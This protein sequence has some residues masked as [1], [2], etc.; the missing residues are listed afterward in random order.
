MRS[1]TKRDNI[2][3]LHFFN[4]LLNIGQHEWG[5][6]NFSWILKFFL[7]VGHVLGHTILVSMF[8]KRL[9]IENLPYLFIA[10]ALLTIIGTSVFSIFIQKV[11]KQSLIAYL[12]FGAMVLLFIAYAVLPINVYLFYVVALIASSILLSQLTIVLALFI[13]EQFSPSESERTFPI[14]ESSELVGALTAG[15]LITTLNFHT[16]E[17]IILWM[18][19]TACLLVTLM[20]Y[21]RQSHRYPSLKIRQAKESIHAV[22]H[23]REGLQ[24]LKSLP[25]L[26][27]MMGIAFI[28]FA[29]A[30]IIEFQ[31]TKALHA[32]AG[33]GEDALTHELGLYV[34]IFS[35]VGLILQLFFASRIVHKLGVIKALILHP[36]IV[37]IG[38]SGMTVNYNTA[39]AVGA[40]F[41]YDISNV[42][43]R[44]AYLSS[45]YVVHHKIRERAKALIEGWI[46]PLGM[47][48]G[49]GSILLL[50]QVLH[51]KVLTFALNVLLVC[52]AGIAILLLN[53][54]RMEYTHLSMLGLNTKDAK[55][56]HTS[57]EILSENGHEQNVEIL[58]KSLR[59]QVLTPEVTAKILTT[60]GQLQALEALPILIDHFE[61]E[62]KDIRLAA[63]E[64]VASYEKLE[65]R[66]MHHAFTRYRLSHALMSLF[67][68]EHSHEVRAV[69]VRA[70]ARIPDKEFVPFLL[71]MLESDDPEVQAD[72]IALMNEFHDPNTEPYIRP[73]LN[74]EHPKVR[75]QAIIALW[76]FKRSRIDLLVQVS[77]MLSGTSQEEIL[78]LL[79]M[80]GEIE[81]HQEVKRIKEYLGSEDDEI[82]AFAAIALAKLEYDESIPHIVS[83]LISTNH[84]LSYRIEQMIEDIPSRF[85]SR[86]KKHMV[87]EAS[88]V[89]QAM[90]A[91]ID[92]DPKRL[93]DLDLMRARRLYEIMDASA[94]V[95][96]ITNILTNRKNDQEH[97]PDQEHARA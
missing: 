39:T 92:H 71:A 21:I 24:N 36:V 16:P 40:K 74:S 9:G 85:R 5:R 41:S 83:H 81:S 68:K 80:L 59:F 49:T 1:K 52:L 60:L 55:H 12:S 27:T 31:Y 23:L 20:L 65:E 34:V 91:E 10:H 50:S 79:H 82:R 15:I 66:Y 95:S 3:D 37:L 29:L 28:E 57:I 46:F 75:A 89:I 47:I 4:H 97:S 17:Y 56:Q 73:L 67:K 96:T 58:V 42:I 13:E 30:P 76:Q 33:G 18:I 51:G 87:H 35:A 11:K 44:N 69:I 86:V 2:L 25:F 32:H 64:A 61:D 93:S 62:N 6:V 77:L 84:G 8:A 48:A 88:R 7:V 22:Q 94:E 54:M 43:Y 38:L 63:V 19:S 78:A 72:T 53:R 26:R 45:Y 14:I 90:L 70:L